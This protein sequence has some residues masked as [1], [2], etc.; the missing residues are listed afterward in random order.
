MTE[1]SR[2]FISVLRNSGIVCAARL[3]KLKSF[4]LTYSRPIIRFLESNGIDIEW[5]SGI[6]NQ[7]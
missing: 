6:E 1:M 4:L 3:W 2:L 7:S 5:A